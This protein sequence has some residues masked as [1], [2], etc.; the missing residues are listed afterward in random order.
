MYVTTASVISGNLVIVLNDNSQ[1][2][3]G[4]V[5]GGTGATGATGATGPQGDQGATGPEGITGAT[6]AAGGTGATGATGPVG[7]SGFIGTTGAT[8]PEGATGAIGIPGEQGVT[9][10]TGATGPEGATGATGIGTPGD[11]GATGLTGATGPIGATGAAGSNGDGGATG[12]TGSVQLPFTGIFTITNETASSSVTTGALQVAGGAGIAGTLNASSILAGQITSSFGFLASTSGINVG[13]VSNPF[14]NMYANTF[15]GTATTAFYADLAEI[16][17]TDQMYS[18]GTV[19]QV[20]GEKEVTAIT[21]SDCYV[22]GAVSSNPAYLMNSQGEGQP[23]ALKG[24]V[25]MLVAGPVKKGDPIWPWA[26]GAGWNISNGREPFAF[27]L[28][29]G[30]PGLVECIIK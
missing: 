23:I 13:T 14:A 9:G 6:G 2:T 27:A 22:L 20:G 15:V 28:E 19:V 17:S 29:T 18:P 3:A 24:R 21:T 25:P 11:T 7:A 4:S 5:I 26:S 1:I 16:Y 8:G 12:A 10:T 30:G